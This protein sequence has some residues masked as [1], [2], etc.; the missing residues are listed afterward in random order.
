MSNHIITKCSKCGK[1]INQCRCMC[2]DKTV[3][4]A[5]CDDCKDEQLELNAEE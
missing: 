5:L 1:I 4:Y 3:V 2:K